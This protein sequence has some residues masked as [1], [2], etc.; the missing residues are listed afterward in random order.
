MKNETQ[1]NSKGRQT[2]YIWDKE[3]QEEF[4]RNLP[5][6]NIEE[7]KQGIKTERSLR[8]LDRTI[9]FGIPSIL[10]TSPFTAYIPYFQGR[11][12]L[13][14]ANYIALGMAAFASFVTGVFLLDIY[15][16]SKKAEAEET[17]RLS[18]LESKLK[19]LK[20]GNEK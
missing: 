17:R 4:D 8:F 20:G 9:R 11:Y 16:D 15:S 18:L 14:S 12:D 13:A 3:C 10:L 19:D 2:P 6:K 1:T 5:S 7:V